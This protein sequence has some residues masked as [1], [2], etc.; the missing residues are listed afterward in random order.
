MTDGL[1]HAVKHA[2]GD[3]DLVRV[4][5]SYLSMLKH[6]KSQNLAGRGVHV[7]ETRVWG[8]FMC[9]VQ[10]RAVSLAC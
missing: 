6:M 7:C 8:R 2:T 10:I 1:G 4:C 5:V 9:R 3:C